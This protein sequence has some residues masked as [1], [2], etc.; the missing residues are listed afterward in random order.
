MAS[1]WSYVFLMW[2]VTILCVQP[3][4]RFTFLYNWHIGDIAVIAAFGFHLLAVAQE[5]R[6]IIR[7][8][9]A[10]R[11][12]LTLMA[13]SFISLH[14]GPL[15]TSSEWNALMD[16]IFKNSYVLILAEAMAF[17]VNRVWGLMA[18]LVIA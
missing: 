2:Y 12:A 6:P 10:T 14:A 5:G 8:G 16:I 11:L 17:N 1:R 3:Q 15:Q 4:N 18:T 13:A 7:F 9:R